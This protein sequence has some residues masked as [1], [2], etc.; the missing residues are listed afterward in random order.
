MSVIAIASAKGSPGV[1]TTALALAAV[2]PRRVLVAECDPVGGDLSY[3][4]GQPATPGLLTLGSAAR[5]GLSPAELWRHTQVI[6]GSLPVL[7]GVLVPEHAAALG[8]LWEEL[9]A[10]FA[11][12]GADV[13]IDCGRLDP[14][15]PALALVSTADLVIVMV[16]PDAPGI[17][18]LEG[19][20][21]MLA[22]SGTAASVVLLGERPYRAAEV[23][24]ALAER[25]RAVDVLSVVAVDPA[26][27]RRLAGGS[28]SDR[29]L[30]RSVLIR[31]AR[32]L[33]EALGTRLDRAV[34]R[35]APGAPE[36]TPDAGR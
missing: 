11:E 26:A 10:A 6:S 32:Q 33:T 19:L 18:H 35:D 21:E 27:A 12:V 23:Q 22:H 13:L 28:G 29:A 36:V 17:S 24:A 30:A 7:L 14:P 4:F 20:L 1:T 15:S 31:S 34:G 2:W 5:R 8:P 9:P 25:G 16:R 3:W